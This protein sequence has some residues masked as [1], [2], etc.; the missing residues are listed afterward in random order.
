MRVIHE[1]NFPTRISFFY[2]TLKN[3]SDGR[4]MWTNS[5]LPFYLI[6]NTNLGKELHGQRL[7]LEASSE[8]S[9]EITSLSLPIRKT[10]LTSRIPRTKLRNSEKAI[11]RERGRLVKWPYPCAP[12]NGATR[13]SVGVIL[14]NGIFAP[15]YR[16][17]LASSFSIKQHFGEVGLRLD[18]F[19]SSLAPF[20]TLYPRQHKDNSPSLWNTGANDNQGGWSFYISPRHSIDTKKCCAASLKRNGD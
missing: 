4:W 7:I 6:L 9:R 8:L 14:K 5:H 12:L 15:K 18:F 13:R 3:W 20:S 10:R 17:F 19:R 1:S 11:E 16:T 2:E